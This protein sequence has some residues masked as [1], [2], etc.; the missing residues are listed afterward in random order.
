MRGIC[1][2]CWARSSVGSDDDFFELGGHSLLATR[3]VA[4]IRARSGVEMPVRAV[5][6]TPTVSRPGA[7]ELTRRES[8]ARPPLRPA[9]TRGA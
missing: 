3:L 6:D 5:F 7:I 1:A 9:Q 8:A 2:E 4:R